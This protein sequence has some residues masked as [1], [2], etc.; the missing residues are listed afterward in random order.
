MM[1]HIF[2]GK[3]DEGKNV[4]KVTNNYI[5]KTEQIV[6]AKDEEEAFDQWLDNGGLD[7]DAI[8]DGLMKAMGDVETYYV[9]A[10]SDGDHDIKYQGK[11]VK[12]P[13]EEDDEYPLLIVD[14]LAPEKELA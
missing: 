1:D 11:V 14:D 13:D 4:Y 6:K 8:N 3:D 12:D 7:H 10:F 5:L 9:E 2:L